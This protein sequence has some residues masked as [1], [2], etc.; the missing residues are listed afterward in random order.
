MADTSQKTEKATPQRLKKAREK[1]DFPAS[2][3]FVAAFQF[4]G[5]VI[6]GAAGFPEWLSNIEAAL[7]MAMR[8][9]FTLGPASLTS[10]DV[11]TLFTVLART[12]L[13]P[14]AALGGILM[15]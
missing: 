15:S 13:L 7:R 8:R 11:L 6:L 4:L 1:G 12:A 2:R 14:L 5:F 3:E 10:G 9:A